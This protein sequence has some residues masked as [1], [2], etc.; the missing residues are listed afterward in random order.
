MKIDFKNIPKSQTI[1]DLDIEFHVLYEDQNIL[2]VS[3]PSGLL[4]HEDINEDMNTLD[5]QVLTY[6]YQKGE[7]DPKDSLGFTPGP[8]HRLDRNTSGIVI[9]GKT[10]KALQ[11][12]N[13][14]MKKRHCIEKTYLTICFGH[15]KSQ[16]LF[17]YMKK[18]KN[19]A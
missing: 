16:E 2:V 19:Q 1:F 6:L 5:H 11:D 9:F 13:E 14:I 7:Y 10:L 8:V 3:K 18:D 4:V 12:L 15:M 17:G